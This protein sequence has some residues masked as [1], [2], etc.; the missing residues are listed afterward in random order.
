LQSEFL[1]NGSGEPD[2]SA[3][4]AVHATRS[5]TTCMIR[6]SAAILVMSN[7]FFH[8]TF[9]M[10]EELPVILAE[11]ER[12]GLSLIPIVARPCALDLYDAISRFQA[13]NNPEHPLS[14]MAEWQAEQELVRLART[15][16]SA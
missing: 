3:R 11:H 5:S 6:A 8:S 1:S 4:A 13:F 2:A 12:R 7:H 9:I 15:I 14:A 16:A 10:A